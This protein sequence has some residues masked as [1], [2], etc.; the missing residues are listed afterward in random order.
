MVRSDLLQARVPDYLMTISFAGGMAISPGPDRRGR[1]WVADR[2]A[3][4][5]Q[6][7]D[8]GWLARNFVR[9]R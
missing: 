6:S 2:A 5:S 4:W 3:L 8:L 7:V 1:G 9:V